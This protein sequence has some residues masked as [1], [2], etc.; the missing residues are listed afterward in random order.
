M[1]LMGTPFF[2]AMGASQ[3]AD[4]P[5]AFFILTTL[6]LLF[7]QA[8]SPEESAGRA[9]PRRGSPPGCAPG[10]KTRASSFF[11]SS[12]ASLFGATV[13]AGGWRQALRRT[14]AFL[15]GPCRSC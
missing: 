1:I 5:L 7:F 6:V 3:F 11:W 12:T 2:I 15:A 14:A 8:R 13:Y 4:I 10:R 9:D